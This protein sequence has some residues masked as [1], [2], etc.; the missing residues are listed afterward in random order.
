M[1]GISCHAD[2]VNNYERLGRIVR[3]ERLRQGYDTVDAARAGTKVSRGAWDNV[4]HGRPAKDLTYNRIERRLGWELDDCRRILDGESPSWE[5]ASVAIDKGTVRKLREIL[6]E[7]RE[8]GDIPDSKRDEIL[9]ILDADQ[10]A[11]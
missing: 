7:A 3:E 2:P 9:R 5:R 1:N 4:E 8:R 10:G 11:G 6:D